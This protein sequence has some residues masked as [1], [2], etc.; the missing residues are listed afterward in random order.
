VVFGVEWIC[1]ACNLRT[2]TF[3]ASTVENILKVA[4]VCRLCGASYPAT[5]V[6]KALHP[7]AESE[8]RPPDADPNSQKD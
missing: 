1:P 7:V 8:P 6:A 3:I 2:T 4:V 5:E